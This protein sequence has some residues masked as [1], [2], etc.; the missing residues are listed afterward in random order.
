MS[1]VKYTDAGG[2]TTLGSLNI[3]AKVADAPLAPTL[4]GPFAGRSVD[5]T[6]PVTFAWTYKPGTD[7]GTQAAYALRIA[8]DGGAYRYWNASTQTLQSSQVFNS[9]TT[10]SVVVPANTVANGHTVAW[11][12]ATAESH[13]SLQGPYAGDT[14]FDSG[15]TFKWQLIDP[16]TNE[17]YAFEINPNT[18]GSL[19]RQKNITY[20]STTADDAQIV[21]YEGTDQPQLVTVSGTLL[22]QAQ[23]TN[24]V[25]WYSK[26]RQVLLIDD[27]GRNIW[28][29]FAQFTPNRK[30]T[31]QSPWRHD[32]SAQFYVIGPQAVTAR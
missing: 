1:G 5:W 20:Y 31:V 8:L 19:T 24:L 2:F 23:Y 6:K 9:S 18:G 32:W 30:W 3:T 26:R 29:Y 4:T 11:S 15:T 25:Y 28:V 7:S 13:Y 17:S 16:V 14:G 10:A 27:L 12:V 21:L 22:T